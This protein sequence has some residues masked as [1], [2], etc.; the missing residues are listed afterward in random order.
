MSFQ[1]REE[2]KD[3]DFLE[4][5]TI[6]GR[7]LDVGAFV[8]TDSF[9]TFL[10]EIS[11]QY[12]QKTWS[13]LT[14]IL[15]RYQIDQSDLSWGWLHPGEIRVADVT[16]DA[17]HHF[18]G[19]TSRLLADFDLDPRFWAVSEEV[20]YIIP[21]VRC[22]VTWRSLKWRIAPTDYKQALRLIEATCNDAGWSFHD[23]LSNN[24]NA[25]SIWHQL[26][27]AISEENQTKVASVLEEAKK[28][29]SVSGYRML[30]SS[31]SYF[32][33][34]YEITDKIFLPKV[35]DYEHP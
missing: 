23:L 20:S 5:P 14:T 22:A 12:L 11:E 6:V 7:R 27:Y 4:E 33:E 29:Y 34:K 15:D 21:N 17:P 8:L 24:L 28:T 26:A 9:D 19:W 31:F 16:E 32:L 30:I 35:K 10:K 3:L 25:N 2:F 18:I 1:H 13:Q